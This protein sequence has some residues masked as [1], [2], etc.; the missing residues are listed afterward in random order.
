MVRSEESNHESETV[1]IKIE[2]LH[3]KTKSLTNGRLTVEVS[4]RV[5]ILS[6]LD[7]TDAEKKGT[8]ERLNIKSNGG[9]QLATKLRCHV[10]KLNP[11]FKHW[12]LNTVQQISKKHPKESI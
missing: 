7:V 11:C 2:V 6:K 9:F 5:S 12:C 8:A 3:E 1:D 4:K 10:H